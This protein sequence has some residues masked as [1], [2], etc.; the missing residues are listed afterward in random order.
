MLQRLALVP[1]L[2]ILLLHF[3]RRVQP[4][5]TVLKTALTDQ[6]FN[7]FQEVNKPCQDGCLEHGNCNRELGECECPFGLSGP[8]CQTQLYPACRTTPTTQRIFLG[9]MAPRNC[10][11]YREV[12]KAMCLPE[13]E[14][15]CATHTM[16][17][18]DALFCFEKVGVPE[19]Q[20]ISELPEKM[21][22]PS[23]RWGKGTTVRE[24]VDG[25]PKLRREIQM[26]SQPPS[27]EDTSRTVP[28]SRCERRC[29]ERGVCQDWGQQTICLCFAGF[30]RPDCSQLVEEGAEPACPNGCG[31]RGKCVAGFCKCEPPY[32]GIGCS[33][34]T[35][36]E[37]VPGSVAYPYFPSL[38][39]YMYDIPPNIVG[40]HQFEDGNGGIHPQYESFLRFQGL[41]L[42]DVSGIRTENPHEANLFYIPAFTYY[43]SSNLGDPTG[44][45]VRA[46]NWVAATFPFFN[47]TGGRDHFVLLSGDRGA[48][49]L[50]T[51]PQTENLIR[52][53]HF[54]YERPN[55]T[56]MG[57]LVTNT[58]YGCF[59]A[60]RDVVMPPYVKSNVAGIQGVRAKLEEP[61]GAEALLAGKD[62]LLFFSGDI[63][64]NEPEY[65]GGVRQALALLLANTSYPDVVFKGGYMMMGMGEYESLLRRSKFCL[66]PYG[67]GWGIR[68]I[69]AITHACIPVIIQDKVRQPFEDILHYPDFSVRVS[70]AELPRLV[71]ILR[72]VPEP[73]L[74]RMIKE[75]SRV[76][77]AFLWQPELGG[78]AYNIT[79]ASLRRRLSHVRGD[80]YEA[81]VRRS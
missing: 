70:K 66:A 61:G 29:S 75:N 30:R 50:K 17:L 64:H 51:L 37:P 23:Y 1:L 74:L 8:T 27:V 46:V 73:D 42:N 72:A 81:G 53:T 2:T 35:A 54:G 9:R 36:Y 26:L 34:S 15:R 20:Q 16:Q 6:P 33:R 38:K 31:G 49:Y 4:A 28:L 48:C 21:D 76:Y 13:E 10:Y 52:V 25:V 79:I 44:A 59:K 22:D 78:L 41:F 69:H 67:H 65:S 80:L 7:Q 68:L 60:G 3:V 19:D 47:R 40:P 43:S 62:T 39:I 32:W 55:I 77:R 5:E 18:W 56:D 57:P 45:A 63:R 71:E 12:M 11:C 58:E 24:V 14:T